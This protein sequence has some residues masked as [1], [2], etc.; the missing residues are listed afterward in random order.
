MTEQLCSFEL[1]GM[2]FGVAAVE[3][4]EILRAQPITRVPLADPATAGLMNLR[5]QI[6]TTIDLRARLGL[7]LRDPD[8]CHL[9]VVIRSSEG[10]FSLLVDAIGDVVSLDRAGFELVPENVP[11]HFRDLIA[12]AYKLPDRLLFVLVVDRVVTHCNGESS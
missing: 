2:T 12:G 8:E 5:G 3:V 6:V 7:P 1:A 9:N 11:A 4:Q 10:V